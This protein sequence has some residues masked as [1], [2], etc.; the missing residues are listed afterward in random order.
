MP[1]NSTTVTCL[2]FV[3]A[4][5]GAIYV[6][7]QD[8][9]MSIFDC[10]YEIAV[11]P[12]SL[13]AVSAVTP[14]IFILFMVG[15]AVFQTMRD[16]TTCRF[17]AGILESPNITNAS[18]TILDY[19]PQM[20]RGPRDWLWTQW[21]AIVMA[22][23][24]YLPVLLTRKSY[25]DVILKRRAR[26]FGLYVQYFFGTLIQRPLHMLVTEPIVALVS[27]YNVSIPWTFKTYYNLGKSAQSLSYLGVSLGSLAVCIPFP[28]IDIF[29]Y[30]RRLRSWRQTY[31]SERM[32]PK[33]RFIPAMAASL[34]L[35]V[36]LVVG[37]WTAHY[38]VHWM[39]PILLQGVAMLSCLLIYA[40]AILCVLDTYGPLYG[41]SASSAMM[42]SRYF[43]GFLFPLFSLRM[44]K[45]LGVG[46][47][48]SLLA[49]LM[50]LMAPIPWAFWI[51]G[52]RI[53]KRSSYETNSVYGGTPSDRNENTAMLARMLPKPSFHA[54]PTERGHA[55][56]ESC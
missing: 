6:P 43:V 50:L 30:Q 51:Y 23:A 12:L 35:P 49:V 10:S 36:S 22:A 1:Q 11:L 7:A 18:A 33:N 34:L 25:Q 16:L 27:C 15:A 32:L 52:E 55:H 38:R 9:I 3:S 5:V 4:F 14:P 26:S 2:A 17:F 40:G 13:R 56:R 42:F 53:R 45:R 8:E 44:F 47:A 46:W 19:I 24:T 20:Y 41:A 29:F 21:A 28:F 37:G 48:T 31:G 54:L 39:V